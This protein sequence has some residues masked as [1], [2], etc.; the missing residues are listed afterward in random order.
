MDAFI[1]PDL[2]V[3]IGPSDAW[4]YQANLSKADLR[5]RWNTPRGRD[6]QVTW[7]A[8]AFSRSIIERKVGR[9]AGRIDLRGIILREKNL[10]RADLS[11]VDFFSADLEGAILEQ[12]N[13]EGS[14]L[15]ESNLCSAKF[16][17]A[18][19]KGVFLDNVDY[20]NHTSFLGVDLNSVNFN[21]AALLQDLALGQQRIAHLQRKHPLFSRLL[22]IT[23]DYGRSLTRYSLWVVGVVLTFA[24]IYALSP[25]MIS[26]PGWLNALYFSVVTFVTLGFGD[27]V[28]LTAAGKALVMAEVAIGYLMGGLLVSILARRV[29]GN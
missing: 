8:N 11:N 21:L 6:I 26:K 13:L 10:S 22:W 15:S 29:V 5:S 23:C 20:D 9:F 28:P 17:W 25:G 27:L 18:H 7:E 24:A 4:R 12:A 2:N 14:F 19:M 3:D 16:D 1:D